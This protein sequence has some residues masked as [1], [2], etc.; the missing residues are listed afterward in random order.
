MSD[1]T[2]ANVKVTGDE[3]LTAEQQAALK[4]VEAEYKA[5]KLT[6]VEACE[7]Y[8][9]IRNPEAVPMTVAEFFSLANIA[10]HPVTFKTGNTGYEKDGVVVIA[11]DGTKFRGSF[12][13]AKCGTAEA[14]AA[15]QAKWGDKAKAKGA[16][17][18]G[19]ATGTVEKAKVVESNEIPF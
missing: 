8:N 16:T 14:K 12:R 13:L 15:A 5:G 2:N 17:V 10:K 4:A 9:R 7:R 18:T 1:T 3:N 6:M 11:K 19:K